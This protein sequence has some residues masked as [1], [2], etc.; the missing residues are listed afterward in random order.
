MS[1]KAPAGWSCLANGPVASRPADGEAGLWIF[2]ATHP[3][4]P[5]LSSFC[6]GT[7]SGRAFTWE[8]DQHRPVPVTV[9]ALPSTATALEAVVTPDF[10]PPGSGWLEEAITTYISR[11]AIEE[12]C[13]GATPWAALVSRALPDHA[14]ARD[15][16]TIRQVEH[17]IRGQ[18][19]L[20]GLRDLLHRHAHGC[21]TKDDLVQCWSRAA[22]RDLR[23]WA[24]KTL[25]PT[26]ANESGEAP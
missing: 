9:N 11:T 6:A 14:Y 4:A 20:A 10:Q 12:T 13:P 18:A 7:F 26:A 2:A 1:V 8:S 17:L 15:A 16:A 23:E 19:V 3:I 24:A 21:A 22:G 25:L 5:Y